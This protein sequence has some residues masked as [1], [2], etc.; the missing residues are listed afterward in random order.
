MV[1][2]QTLYL[3]AQMSLVILLIPFLFFKISKLTCGC[4]AVGSAV[5]AVIAFLAAAPLLLIVGYLIL[6]LVFGLT[7]YIIWWP[8]NGLLYILADLWTGR[9][10]E[11]V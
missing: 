10:G 8:S 6:S 2:V 1:L 3:A 5:V 11:D 7:A 9:G 4:L